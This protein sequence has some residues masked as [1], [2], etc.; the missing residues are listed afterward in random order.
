MPRP[1]LFTTLA[2][3]AVLAIT[4]CAPPAIED[5]E[6]QADARSQARDWAERKLKSLSLDEKVGQMFTHYAYGQTSGTTEAADVK[7]NQ[8]LH[9][10]DNADELIAKYKL[11]GVIYFNWSN[12]L[13]D[14]GKIA[15]LSNGM[16]KTAL[17]QDAGI[18]LL[19]AT[20]QETGTVVRLGPPATEWPGNMALGAGRDRGDARDAA[21]IAGVELRAVGINQNF[22]PSGDVNVNPEN[23]VIGTRSY[24]SD[25]KMV[26]KFTAEQVKG[27]QGKRGTAATVKHFPGHGDTHEDSHTD[28]P[29]I[30]HTKEQFDELD[31]P[32]FKAAIKAGVDTVMSAHIQFPALDET[33]KPATLSKPILTGILREELG[34]DGVIT[35]D[36]LGMQG[37]RELY[38]DAEIPVMA[39]K[40]GVDQLL[41]PAKL[42]VA[43]K[44]VLEAVKS[45]EISEKRINQSV[46]RLLTLKYLRGVVKNPYVDPDKVDDLVGTKDHLAFA[47][48]I[49]DKTT[50]LVKNDDDA[51]PLSTGTGKVLVAGDGANTTRILAE[52]IGKLGPGTEA[53]NTGADPNAATIAGA[54]DKAKQSDV[55]VVATNTVRAHPAQAELVRA[56]RDSG[57]KVVVVGVKEPYDINRFPEVDSYVASYGYNT[58]VLTATAK[59]LFGELD[60]S[61]KLPVKIPEATDPDSTLYEFGHGLSYE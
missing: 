18:P 13:A 27:Y 50:T 43:Y 61:G 1:R 39:V 4:G 19:V 52:Q 58:P 7:R 28:L 38:T 37:V 46:K 51:L 54:V 21:A 11:G 5:G 10:V 23:P 44:A 49:T 33:E 42:D 41:M 34:F 2:L 60:P 9:G 36:S 14:P 6:P 48:E 40:A 20:D 47:Q 57:V 22:A 17:A 12:N 29:R 59:V 16:Q 26:A 31:A 15:G 25:P 32:P 53:L 30:E 56:L 35:T 3:A 45:G 24:S 55:V 8:A